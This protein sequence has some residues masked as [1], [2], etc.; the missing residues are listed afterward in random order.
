MSYA[1]SGGVDTSKSGTMLAGSGVAALAV[2]SVAT[3][4]GG[5]LDKRTEGLG[6]ERIVGTRESRKAAARIGLHASIGVT[7]TEIDEI[8]Q[9]GAAA[10]LDRQMAVPNDGTSVEFFSTRGLDRID[11]N[12]HW[13]NE[14]YF[15]SMIWAHLFEGGNA[16]RKRMALALSEIFVVSLAGIEPMWRAHAAGA[17]W[18][19]LNAHAFS[20][21]RTLLEAVTLSP[22]MGQYLNMKGNKA[23]DPSTG[24]MPDENFARE[25]M[26]L[27]TIGLF[28]LNL[29]GSRVLV[30]GQ[31]VPTYSNTDVEG[32][33]KVFTGF[34]LDYF[35]LQIVAS[36]FP[37]PPVPDVQVVRRPM[38]S[39]PNR[40]SPQQTVSTHSLE[41]KRFLGRVIQPGT[42][43]DQS[44]KL[45]LDW[46]ANHQNVAPFISKQL[47][48]RLVTSNP[49]SSYVMRV[50]SVFNN[51]GSGVRGDL[52]AVFKA[53][54]LDPEAVD[55]SGV[56]NPFFG[57]VRE[58]MLR[59]A[60][61]GRTFRA[62]SVTG[63]WSI[64]PMNPETLLNQ[65]PFRSPSVFNFFRP[66]YVPPRSQ[67]AA[68]GM[69]APELQIAT[70]NAVANY[71]NV[72]YR[73]VYENGFW[74]EI[75]KANYEYEISIAS[76]ALKLLDH[77]DLI[78]TAGQLSQFTRSTVFDV[79]NN[80]SLSGLN[81]GT[82]ILERV[83]QAVVLIMCSNDYL[84]Q[85]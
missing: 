71:V 22:A 10:W 75:L 3:V 12:G 21:F 15:D 79:V 24:R 63:A 59:F 17:Y 38:T 5:A 19:L 32:L 46:L 31:P 56:A 34:D 28:E 82:A 14:A 9:L 47:I 80:I 70:D 40:W 35:G 68:N 65:S 16:V 67:A 58:P 23:A 72:I 77:L 44:L 54:I 8:D 45:A 61:W 52:A 57:K 20:N 30:A 43:P 37:G 49:S 50:A 62:R 84:V 64:R 36:P 6:G 60:Q 13:R 85:K 74:S 11:Q 42:G 55:P 4:G 76:D 51:N 26:Q 7:A 78:I 81:P 73:T 2:A 29:D 39:R 41:E 53:I 66:D 83:R 69:A 18:D 27:F 1:T 25:I 33:A 48:Q